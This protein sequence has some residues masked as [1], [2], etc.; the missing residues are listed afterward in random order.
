MMGACYLTEWTEGLTHLYDIGNEIE[1]YRS[2]EELVD[3]IAELGNDKAR[4]L[5]L[6]A[7]GQRR[8][9]SA[10]AIGRSLQRIFEAIGLSKVA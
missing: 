1:T 7:A 6:R 3:K 10:L 4:R 9:L 2:A 5:A 8:A